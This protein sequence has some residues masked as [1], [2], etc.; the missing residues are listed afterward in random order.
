MQPNWGR[1]TGLR[2]A[3]SLVSLLLLILAI[4]FRDPVLI[5]L[6]ALMVLSNVPIWAVYIGAR[7]SKRSSTRPEQ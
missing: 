7:I 3:S 1:W 4:V 6:A 5:V 2:I